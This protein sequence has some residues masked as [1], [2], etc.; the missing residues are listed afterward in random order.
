[1]RP[2]ISALL[3]VC[4]LAFAGIA[5]Q[6]CGP[7]QPTGSCGDGRCDYSE[8]ESNY[9]CPADCPPNG[10]G[11]GP[12]GDYCGDHLPP[13]PSGVL[14]PVGP[15]PQQ[16]QQW[17]WAA[18]ITMVANYYDVPATE[19]E[20]ASMKAGF[21]YPACCSY[22]ACSYQACDQPAPTNQIEYILGQ[23]IGIHG[24]AENAAISEAVLQTE[25]ANGRPVIIGYLNSFA[26]HVVLAIGYAPGPG[27][28]RYRIVDPYYGVFD[29]TY[30]Q[31]AYGYMGGG[32]SWR[33]GYTAYHLSPS[34]D[35][36]NLDWDPYCA[37]E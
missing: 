20:L 19:C 5:A 24:Y 28:T 12:G 22:A 13:D 34:S 4:L 1:M 16:C 3:T 10:P 35:G 36:C 6:G 23:I 29:V 17:C 15:M 25:L 11:P 14:L 9:A 32:A 2:F 33:W 31:V 30:Q 18:V 26:G 8:G 21:N 27:G 37:C 7:A